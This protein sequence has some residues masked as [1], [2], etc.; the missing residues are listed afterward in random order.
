[1]GQ[2]HAISV[3][4]RAYWH[5]GGDKRYLKAAAAGL[6]PFRNLSKDGGVLALFMDKY[7]W[8]VWLVY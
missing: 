1:M 3:L 8:L 6:K 7:F 2:G 4:A 5:S